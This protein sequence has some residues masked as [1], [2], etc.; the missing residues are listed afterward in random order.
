VGDGSGEQEERPIID[1]NGNLDIHATETTRLW[2]TDLYLDVEGNIY[3]TNG[4][5]Y[6]TGED[7]DYRLS[8]GETLHF[9]K[10]IF[11]GATSDD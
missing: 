8:N 6:S 2:C 1:A 11:I 5:G 3:V 4:D 7:G 10:G 9:K